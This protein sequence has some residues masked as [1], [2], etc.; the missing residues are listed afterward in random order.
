MF[1]IGANGSV[2]WS[3][4]VA[5]GFVASLY[6]RKG[7]VLLYTSAHSHD[8]Y[9][10]DLNLSSCSMCRMGVLRMYRDGSLIKDAS[11]EAFDAAVDAG[12]WIDDAGQDT[13]SFVLDLF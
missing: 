2:L 12:E 3:F 6:M 1:Q 13:Y 9:A 8:L 5:L 11:D 10:R 7:A 4:L